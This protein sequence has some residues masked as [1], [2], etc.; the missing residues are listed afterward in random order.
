MTNKPS[1]NIIFAGTPAF[2][3]EVLDVLLKSPHH[4][5][6][7]YTQPD[8]PSGRGQKLMPSPV[9]A[10]ALAHELPVYQP[11]NLHN[12]E[13]LRI[14][15]KYQAD[16]MVV[17]AYGLILPKSVLETPRLGCINIHA[18]LLPRWRGAA[19][20]QRAI[21]SGDKETGITIMQM[22]Q[23]LDTGPM[24]YKISCPIDPQDTSVS[25][26]AKLAA[27]GAN[28]LLHT[29]MNFPTIKPEIQDNTL[30]TYAHKIVKEE[31]RINW[32]ES[33]ESIARKIRGFN[34]WP[35]M[36]TQA[37]EMILRIWEAVSLQKSSE[38]KDPGTIVA[39]DAK[40]IEVLTGN[41]T[42]LIEKLQLPGGRVLSAT[43]VVNARYP[44]LAVGK[45]LG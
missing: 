3:A 2:A 17:V 27:M 6:A 29:L 25:L 39:A 21:V 38:Q 23:G 33:A 32:Y 11:T 24:L 30:A 15:A 31:A 41:G 9:K 35:I 28:A 7:V 40:G 4:V 18:S 44:A 12:S 37:G 20:I 22:D 43:D 10:L 8:R 34:P 26:H 14:L 19:P 45:K 1:Y 13:E 36:Q 5:V 16:I 42:L